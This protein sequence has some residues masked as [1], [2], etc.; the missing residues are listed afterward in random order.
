MLRPDTS[1]LA[2]RIAVSALSARDAVRA[3][4]G[5]IAGVDHQGAAAA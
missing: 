5:E 3:C 1:I 4:R 2:A